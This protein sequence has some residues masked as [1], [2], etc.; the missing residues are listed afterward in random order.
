MDKKTLVENAIRAEGY[1]QGFK[2]GY[3]S[4]VKFIMEQEKQSGSSVSKDNT[5]ES[6]PKIN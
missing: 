2:D 3:H 5:G 6:E 4:C 1:A